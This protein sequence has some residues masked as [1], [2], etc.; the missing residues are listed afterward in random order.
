MDKPRF[1]V[2]VSDLDGVS[3]LTNQLQ[4]PELITQ[5]GVGDLIRCLREFAWLKSGK[6]L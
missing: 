6:E 2:S 4:N 1:I 5:K 3:A